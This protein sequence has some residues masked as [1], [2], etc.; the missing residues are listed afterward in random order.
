MRCPAK[1]DAASKYY[2]M[3][4]VDLV[5]ELERRDK[6]KADLIAGKGKVR[7]G[8]SGLSPTVMSPTGCS[9]SRAA[10]MCLGDAERVDELAAQAFEGR[11][12]RGARS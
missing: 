6:Y 2:G 1:V 10:L 3:S 9:A 11:A 12:V 7:W 4:A 8:E 5:K